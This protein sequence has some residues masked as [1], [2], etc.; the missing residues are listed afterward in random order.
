MV[1]HRLTKVDQ[2]PWAIWKT[3]PGSRGKY[4]ASEARFDGVVA[5]AELHLH[6]QI[7][8]KIS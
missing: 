2:K 8:V 5:G 4:E 3:V 7:D 1:V 6:E